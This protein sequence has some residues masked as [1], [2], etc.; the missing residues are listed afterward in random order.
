MPQRRVK[1]YS[2]DEDDQCADIRRFI[3]EGGLILE[4]RDLGKQPL[5]KDELAAMFGHINLEHFLNKNAKSYRKHGLDKGL[6]PR[7]ELLALIAEDNTLLRRPIIRTTRLITV[8]CDKDNLAR[9]LQLTFDEAGEI[10]PN[11]N[12]E[13]SRN[14][15]GSSRKQTRK[16]ASEAGATAAK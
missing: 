6:P 15:N 14:A 10:V 5:N 11:R 7:D 16:R 4:L 3:E 2:Y 12:S 13:T 1:Y 9:M 8:G